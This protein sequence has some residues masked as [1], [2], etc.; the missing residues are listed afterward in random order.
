MFKPIFQTF[1][2]FS[3]RSITSFTPVVAAISLQAGLANN[4][5]KLQS[6]NIKKNQTTHQNTPTHHNQNSSWR[7]LQWYHPWPSSRSWSFLYYC[8]RRRKRCNGTL[9]LQ[10]TASMVKTHQKWEEKE[11]LEKFYH[12]FLGN[13][14]VKS[15]Y[16]KGLDLLSKEA[17]GSIPRRNVLW[18]RTPLKWHLCCA[19][20][21]GAS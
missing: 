14:R 12:S 18:F 1:S 10:D 11:L 17:R 19:Q 3:W 20:K 6:F 7:L 16:N 9:G 13:R 8:T 15:R 2:L 4:N 5:M 21:Q